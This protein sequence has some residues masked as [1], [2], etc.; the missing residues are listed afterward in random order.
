MILPLPTH[1]TLS[2]R[3]FYSAD[4]KQRPIAN[5]TEENPEE[6][7]QEHCSRSPD[8]LGEDFSAGHLSEPNYRR[9]FI[10]IFCKWVIFVF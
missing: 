3:C 9:H 10:F 2:F 6:D 8:V 1:R 7:S 4:G 5:S